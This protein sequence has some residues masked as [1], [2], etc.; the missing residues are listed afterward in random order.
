MA[1][2]EISDETVEILRSMCDVILKVTGRQNL[3]AVVYVLS[4][5]EKPLEDVCPGE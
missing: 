1:K 3:N 2:Y 5:L 4:V